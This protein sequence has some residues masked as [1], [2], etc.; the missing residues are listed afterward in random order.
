MPDGGAD[1]G[2][3]AL[4]LAAGDGT[5]D[6]I[7]DARPRGDGQERRGEQEGEGREHGD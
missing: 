2:R 3:D 1:A 7:R 6:D 5:G 4:C